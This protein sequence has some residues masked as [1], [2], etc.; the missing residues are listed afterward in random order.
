MSAREPLAPSA[1]LASIDDVRG[2]NAADV[3]VPSRVVHSSEARVVLADETGAL[4]L[5]L[6]CAAP[7]GGT[8][9]I[10]TITRRDGAPV[11]VALEASTAPLGE[12]PRPRGDWWWLHAD[13]GRR[14]RLL[15][16]RARATRAAREWLDGQGFVEV[17]TPLAAPSPG[18]D[19]HLDALEVLG[20]RE[21]RWL[22][23]SPE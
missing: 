13:G 10:A 4:E 17:E 14:M 15:H 1:G 16:Q 9:A 20:G 5:A 11:C 12:F 19:V 21:P 7:A 8:W 6:A 22:V 23:T 3:R 18:L 2:G